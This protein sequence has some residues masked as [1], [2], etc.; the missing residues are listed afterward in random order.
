MFVRVCSAAERGSMTILAHQRSAHLRRLMALL[1]ILPEDGEERGGGVVQ[2]E[3]NGKPRLS[4]QRDT[5]GH[6]PIWRIFEQG[7]GAEAFLNK[8]EHADTSQGLDYKRQ[9][10]TWQRYF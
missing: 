1:H 9:T 4:N 5:G 6:R 7:R 3:Q 10:T 8:I 2:K